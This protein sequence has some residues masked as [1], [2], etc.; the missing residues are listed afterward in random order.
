MKDKEESK[1]QDDSKIKYNFNPKGSY[2][3]GGF[4]PTFNPSYSPIY[5]TY[6]ESEAKGKG[7][8]DLFS[9][10]MSNLNE[11][12]KTYPEKQENCNGQKEALNM[13]LQSPI[14]NAFTPMN[15]PEQPKTGFAGNHDDMPPD[16]S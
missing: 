16:F 6:N 7:A 1:N 4:H 3:T 13:L 12:L 14:A 11:C 2:S 10:A 9:Q 5:N 15:I 8:S